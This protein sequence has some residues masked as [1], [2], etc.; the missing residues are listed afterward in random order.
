MTKH[1]ITF[2]LFILILSSSVYADEPADSTFK[3]L[4]EVVVTGTRTP[5]LLKDTPIQTQLV[6]ASDIA[7]A[8]AT[9]VRDVLQTQLPGIE[10]SY[11]MGQ[12]VH[13]NF[14]GF[15]GQSVL[16]LIDGERLAGESMDDVDF[17][18]ILANNMARIEIVK[19]AASALYGSNANGGVINIITKQPTEKFTLNLNGRYAR[20]N[21]GRFGASFGLNSKHWSNLL[22]VNFNNIDS[23]NVKSAPSN[24]TRVIETVYGERTWDFKE[25]LTYRPISNLSIIA[26]AGYYFKQ[27]QRQSINEPERY[28]DFSG[29]LRMLWDV[30]PNNSLDISYSFDQYDKSI[31]QLISKLDVRTYSNVQNSMRALFTH[32]FN[33]DNVLTVGADYMHDY[34]YNRN[35][36]DGKARWQ[37][38]F[39]AF[40]EYDWNI[41]PQWEMVGALRYDYFSDGK[42]SRLTPKYNVR[43]KPIDNVNIRFGYG[44]GFRAPAL[45]EKYYNFPLLSIWIIEGNPDL[46]PEVSHNFN[47]SADFT[48]GD[49]NLT[50]MG[51]FNLVN[52]KLSTGAPFYKSPHDMVPY[53]TYQNFRTYNVAGL[54]LSAQAHWKN[55]FGA[56]VAYA[57]THEQFPKDK[58]GNLINNQYIPARKHSLTCYADYQHRFSKDYALTVS[59]NGRVLSGVTN[60]EFKSYYDISQGTIEVKY[61]PYTIWKL[62]LVQN[63][64]KAVRL[65]LAID[66][67]FNYKPKYYYLNCPPT[68]GADFSIGVSIDVEKFFKK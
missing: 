41:S 28:R 50:A 42:L 47:L 55:G 67:L 32:S 52:N 45:K 19:G 6:T 16:F 27:A 56:R 61:P 12:Q 4:N 18:R 38:I 8:D 20:H 23:Y 53:L 10:F 2:F 21:N 57:Y 34:L 15:G 33:R 40:A 17:S 1:I 58:D 3:N 13:M 51:Y 11:S 26:R 68:D 36:Q 62:S 25:K 46:K 39:D 7:R 64:G 35:L 63:I 65:T 24:V 37:D 59:L 49:Y 29:G 22:S 14:F 31:Y 66:N 48:K 60:Y 44:M 30:S 5:K 43:Y 9:D 54:E